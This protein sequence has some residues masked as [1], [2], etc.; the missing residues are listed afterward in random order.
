MRQRSGEG[1]IASREVYADYIVDGE[2]RHSHLDPARARWGEGVHGAGVAHNR[3]CPQTTAIRNADAHLDV[4]HRREF[5]ADTQLLGF[6][7]DVGKEVQQDRILRGGEVREEAGAGLDGI[8]AVRGQDWVY[9]RRE[10][11]AEALHAGLV[12]DGF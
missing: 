9:E 4:R 5:L 7:T 1:V 2:C 3:Y 12:V 6:V 11:F 10:V 8:G